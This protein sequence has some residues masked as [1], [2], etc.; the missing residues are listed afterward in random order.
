MKHSV[1]LLENQLREIADLIDQGSFISI[2]QQEKQF[3]RGEVQ[4]LAEKLA[5]IESGFLTIGLL[6]GTGVGKSTLMNALAGSVIAS[7]SHRRPHT[8][9]VLI[10]RHFEANSLPELGLGDTPWREIIHES[11]TIRQILLCD[12]PDFDSL[13][14]N[15]RSHVQQFLEHLDVLVWVTSPEKYADGRFY[16]FLRTVPKAKQNFYFL[17]NKVDLLFDGGGLEAGYEQMA[18]VARSFQENVR[19]IG[20]PQPLFY[21]VSAREIVDS[22][23]LAP[24]NQFPGFRQQIL[25]QRDIKQVAAI[26]AANLDVE[27]Q[28]LLSH[29]EKEIRHLKDFEQVL[30]VSIKELQQE[31]ASWVM[32]GEQTFDHWL[33]NLARQEVLSRNVDPSALLGLGYTLALFIQGWKR[34]VTERRNALSSFSQLEVP[35]EITFPFRRRLEW[36]QDRL[37]HQVLRKS[38][39]SPFRERLRDVFEVSKEIEDLKERFS[40][41]LALRLS[42]PLFPSFWGFRGL[43]L[44]TYVLLLVFFVLA[45]GGETAW[46]SVLD[47][48][49]VTSFFHLL[50]SGIHT[51]F[52]TKGLAAL[53]SYALLNLFFAIRFYR[54]YKKLSGKVMQRMVESLKVE[55]RMVWQEK[56]AAIVNNLNQLA[57]DIQSQMAAISSLGQRK[58]RG[59]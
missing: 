31:H 41:V 37:D 25:Q 4:D 10:Y 28:L 22:D 9:E 42:A 58:G 27:V 26:K 12:L 53:G 49:G 16:E 54:R 7:T 6:G 33:G 2:T 45:I 44:L 24:W 51:L 20:I 39:P 13:I 11:D 18:S 19:A 59:M 5:A 46:R 35:E 32:A 48:P 17:L 47:D 14:S 36:L 57:S 29:F 56:L 38:L 34:R 43:Q 1:P 15:H 50:L 55:L 3:L 21:I 40:Q 30:Q 52:S 23:E 8:D